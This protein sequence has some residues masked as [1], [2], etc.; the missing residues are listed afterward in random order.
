VRLIGGR[1]EIKKGELGMKA[2]KEAGNRFS[3]AGFSE[4]HRRER[5]PGKEI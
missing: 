1:G 5:F 2:A 3:R 4:V